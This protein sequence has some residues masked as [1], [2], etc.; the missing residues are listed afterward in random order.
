MVLTI[1]SF[2][3]S[4]L[5]LVVVIDYFVEIFVVDVLLSSYLRRLRGGVGC[6]IDGSRSEVWAF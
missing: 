1:H 5:L 6:V 2:S 4:S 3:S